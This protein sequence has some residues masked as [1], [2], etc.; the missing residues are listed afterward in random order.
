MAV[1]RNVSLRFMSQDSVA[2][3]LINIS[4][5]V[6]SCILR[7]DVIVCSNVCRVSITPVANYWI[8]EQRMHNYIT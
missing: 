3:A 4:S 7:S 1:L 8:A 2:A 5:D 6:R